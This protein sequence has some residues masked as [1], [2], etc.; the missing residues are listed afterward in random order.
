MTEL[1]RGDVWFGNL[2]PV[3]GHEQAGGR[4]LLIVS[5][6]AFHRSPAGLVTVVPITRTRRPIP[7]HLPIESG[8]GGVRAPS[9]ILCD[10]LR[11]IAT[12][13]LYERRG[14]VH[15]STLRAVEERLRRLLGL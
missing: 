3:R 12:E 2:D 4:P 13:R 10:Q 6:N 9:A 14:R 8:E 1:S 15:E 5:I 7:F 11:T